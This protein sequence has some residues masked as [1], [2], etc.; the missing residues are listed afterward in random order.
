MKKTDAIAYF[1]TPTAVARALGIFPAAVYQWGENVPPRR[2]Y[3]LEKI[4]DGALK[5][6]IPLPQKQKK[7]RKDGN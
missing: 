6:N 4:T 5:A 3:E 1:G 7:A 2:A